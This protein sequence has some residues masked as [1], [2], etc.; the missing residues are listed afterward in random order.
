M[1]TTER[2]KQH[3]YQLAE[4]IGERNVFHPDALYAAQ[5]YITQ[6]WQQQGYTV[7]EQH[8]KAYGVNCKN[9]EINHSG[10]SKPEEIILVGAHYDSVTGAP[11]ANDNGSGVAAMLELSRLAKTTNH[12]R[13]M[14]FVAF[15]NEEP[16]FFFTELQG[17]R[18]Y[19][20]AAR[21]RDDDIR[22]MIALETIGYYKCEPNTQR[23]PPL[24]RF[25]YPD[26]ADFIS[27]V[28]NLR[29]RNVMLK[30]ARAF[31]RV[32]DFPLQHISTFKFV[33]GVSWSDHLSFWSRGYKALMVTDTAFYRYPYYH[34][35]ED[36]PEKLDYA[37]LARVTEGL[38]QAIALL[39][40]SQRL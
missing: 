9:L 33:P 37:R 15:V 24:F 4:Q 7:T 31:R 23:Y 30:L 35:K 20:K 11:G 5:N 12:A 28:C 16:P 22:L 27:L 3:V 32:S 40:S 14:R 38:S 1:P 26:R 19:A 6:T 34:T 13:S 36:T 25:F 17:S 21:E 29:S 18:I 10:S 39:A 8:Y 2:L